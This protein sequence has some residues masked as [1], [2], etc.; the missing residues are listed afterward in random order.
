MPVGEARCLARQCD[1]FSSFDGTG[2]ESTHSGEAVGHGWL[3]EEMTHAK[4]AGMAELEA[5][6][7]LARRV[8]RKFLGE[9][10]ECVVHG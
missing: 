2:E 5:Q 7:L 8:Q 4:C 10:F 3:I 1:Q 9:A 6:P